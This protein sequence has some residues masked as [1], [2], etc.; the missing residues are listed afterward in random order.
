MGVWARDYSQVWE[1]INKITYFTPKTH[2]SKKI[3]VSV[4]SYRDAQLTDTIDSLFKNQ[5]GQNEVI[6]G[7]CMQDTEENYNNFKYKDHPNVRMYFMP[8][9]EAKGVGYARN[10]PVFMKPGDV[11]EVEI[12][13]IGVLRNTIKDE[14]S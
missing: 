1:D 10:P 7:V 12:Q 6:V 8:Y 2:S 4:A 3:L 9:K 5:S 11:I 13:D 14:I